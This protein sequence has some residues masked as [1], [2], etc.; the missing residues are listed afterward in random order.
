MKNKLFLLLSAILVACSTN[1]TINKKT[2]TPCEISKILYQENKQ[3]EFLNSLVYCFDHK[4]ITNQDY[5]D[6]FFML[7]SATSVVEGTPQAIQTFKKIK[8]TVTTTAPL[9]I[10]KTFL[11]QVVKKV[12]ANLIGVPFS[13]NITGHSLAGWVRVLDE[14]TGKYEFTQALLARIEIDNQLH[15]INIDTGSNAN[16]F[17]SSLFLDNQVIITNSIVSDVHK[18]STYAQKG[19][20]KN[21]N[22]F[23]LTDYNLLATFINSSPKEYPIL[24]LNFLMKF[25]NFCIDTHGLSLNVEKCSSIKTWQPMQLSPKL[26]LILEVQL[27]GEPSKL[28]IDTGSSSNLINRR[29]LSY[30]QLKALN[31][32]EVSLQT[33]KGANSIS[34][35]SIQSTHYQLSFSND[36]YHTEFEIVHDSEIAMRGNYH[37][38][39]GLEFFDSFESI[40]FDF[41]NMRLGLGKRKT[42]SFSKN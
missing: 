19:F 14:K 37:G 29:H 8:K 3:H 15:G 10:K 30:N 4:G 35:L 12:D 5:Y 33:I 18:K 21:V 23:G 17:P 42:K 11:K 20:V 7:L 36:I 6:L 25:S 16:I 38:L 2:N 39:L 26:A 22:F 32:V 27:N 1:S 41:K 28:L 13:Q 31:D 24:G 9:Q 34:D 40:M